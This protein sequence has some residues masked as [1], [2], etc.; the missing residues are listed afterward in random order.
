MALGMVDRVMGVGS[1]L[2]TSRTVRLGDH[3]GLVPPLIRALI[4][5]NDVLNN[6]P[7]VPYQSMGS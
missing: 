1:H 5:Q 7:A 2:R 4:A 6:V 3:P